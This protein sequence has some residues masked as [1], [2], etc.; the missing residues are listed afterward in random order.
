MKDIETKRLSNDELENVAGGTGE[1]ENISG[2]IVNG[3]RVPISRDR[4]YCPYCKADFDDEPDGA[5]IFGVTDNNG[6]NLSFWY[7]PKSYSHLYAIYDP[8]N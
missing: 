7:C 6:K 5:A 4:Y 3:Q 8:Y 1:F 2:V